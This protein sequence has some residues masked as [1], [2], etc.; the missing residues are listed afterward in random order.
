MS[1]GLVCATLIPESDLPLK[2]IRNF[3]R[4]RSLYVGQA[5]DALERSGCNERRQLG[6]CKRRVDLPGASLR[7]RSTI[8]HEAQ[9]CARVTVPVVHDRAPGER[10]SP[11]LAAHQ[12]G[13]LARRDT[14]WPG[15]KILPCV[16]K[17]RAG[18]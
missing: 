18:D 11:A 14:A 5:G 9:K 7:A 2:L 6:G 8:V 13:G 16:T 1:Q 15:F 10:D 12:A 17:P 3:R 4:N